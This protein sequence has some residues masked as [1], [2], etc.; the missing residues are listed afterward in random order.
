MAEA[1]ENRVHEASVANVTETG[2]S[3]LQRVLFLSEFP[4]GPFVEAPVQSLVKIEW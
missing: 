3:A 2:S 1:L 4:A